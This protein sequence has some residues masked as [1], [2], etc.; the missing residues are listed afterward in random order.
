MT[1]TSC[2]L[3]VRREKS[4]RLAGDLELAAYERHERDFESPLLW[5]DDDEAD[6]AVGFFRLLKHWKGQW[7]GQQFRLEPWQ[8]F[9]VRSLFGWMR[10]DGTRRFRTAYIEVPRKNGKTMLVSGLGLFLLLADGEQG[11]EVYSTATKLDQAKIVWNDARRMVQKSAALKKHISIYSTALVCERLASKFA[12]LGADSKTL[13]GLNPH[14][15]IVDELHAHKSR[16]VWDVME[17]ALGARQ[18][19]MTLAITT[20]GLYDPTAVGWEQHVYA[21]NVL[22]G[23]FDDDSFFAFIS[24]ADTDSDWRD[25]AVW[26][27][28]NPNLDVSIRR[29]YL[30]EQCARADRS[31]AFLNT[32][33]R[34]HLNVWTQQV[35]RWLS[36]DAWN[37]CGGVFDIEA[38]VGE[39][40]YLGL[41]LA[42]TTDL[43]ALALVFPMADGSVRVVVEHWCPEATVI[44]RTEA[45]KVPYDAWVRDGWI[46]TTPGEVIDYE[47]IRDRIHELSEVHAIAEIAYDPWNATQLSL[48][49]E[50][51]GMVMVPCRQ[52]YPTMSDPSKRFEALVLG[53][54]LRHGDNPVLRWQVNNVAIQGGD[55]GAIRPSKKR[56]QDKIDGIVAIIMA[57]WRLG[58]HDGMALDVESVYESRGVLVL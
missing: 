46:R 3:G 13:D 34:Y 27:R 51:D 54:K 58:C 12:P 52:G 9:I 14:G 37:A 6:R 53:G 15:N 36:M 5:F 22:R 23:V 47:I 42:S 25:P 57:L 39:R 29:S 26:W 28:A 18:Q 19:P 55:G 43:A 7:A 56:S 45:D 38:M 48:Q 35:D 10:A 33:L 2:C 16:A 21:E 8:E 41:D 4:V 32:F 11:A 50:R 17:T 40:C 30:E 20:A 24:A 31:P 1:T 44:R 49:L